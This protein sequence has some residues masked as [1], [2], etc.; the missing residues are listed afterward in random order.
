MERN[1]LNKENELTKETKNASTQKVRTVHQQTNHETKV[2]SERQGEGES[3][4]HS[5][6]TITNRNETTQKVK[7]VQRSSERWAHQ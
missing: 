2:G 4:N 7:N 6:N 3:I 1:F 5:A